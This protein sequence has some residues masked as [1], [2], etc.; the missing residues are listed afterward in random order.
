MVHG[1]TNAQQTQRRITLESLHVLFFFCCFFFIF[2]FFVSCFPPV[3]VC[4]FS[5]HSPIKKSKSLCFLWCFCG[6]FFPQT[7]CN[8]LVQSHL[9]LIHL[10]SPVDLSAGVRFLVSPGISKSWHFL[11]NMLFVLKLTFIERPLKYGW[12]YFLFAVFAWFV[13]CCPNV[14]AYKIIAINCCNCI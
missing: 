12:L 5:L 1:E 3:G 8:Y 7:S 6:F 14:S 4:R 2:F 9:T 11:K 13:F 10:P